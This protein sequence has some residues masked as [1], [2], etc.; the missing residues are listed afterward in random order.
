[1]CATMPS[2]IHHEAFSYPSMPSPIHRSF[3]V[4]SDISIDVRADTHVDMCVDVCVVMPS[5]HIAP[6]ACVWT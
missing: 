4:C 5:S 2:S 6:P 1:M 3:C